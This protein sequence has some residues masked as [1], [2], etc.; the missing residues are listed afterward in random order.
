MIGSTATP[1]ALTSVA[2]GVLFDINGDGVRERVAWTVAGAPVGFLALDRDGDGAIDSLGELF[3]QVA[4]GQRRPE[5]TANSFP[6]LAA[7][8]RPENGGNGDG[9]ISA[10]DAVFAQLRLWVDANHD[11]VSQPG[12]LADAGAGGDRLD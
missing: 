2:G 1:C 7:F 12:E 10:A 9:V 5:G 6:D 4:S 8:D 11:G 3:G